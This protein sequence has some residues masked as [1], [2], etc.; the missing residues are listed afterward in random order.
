MTRM[1]MRKKWTWGVQCK[2]LLVGESP[3]RTW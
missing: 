2:V 3:K 1:R